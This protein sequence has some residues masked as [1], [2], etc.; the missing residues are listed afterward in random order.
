A[1]HSDRA[2]VRPGAGGFRAPLGSQA[3]MLCG[4]TTVNLEAADVFLPNPGSDLRPR[5]ILAF[6]QTRPGTRDRSFWGAGPAWVGH[7]QVLVWP[8]VRAIAD[9]DPMSGEHAE[10][11]AVGEEFLDHRLADSSCP[12]HLEA[13]DVNGGD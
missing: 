10:V 5:I 9:H 12:G 7:G 2:E 13:V 1:R 8:Q 4:I 6:L 11:G 3:Y